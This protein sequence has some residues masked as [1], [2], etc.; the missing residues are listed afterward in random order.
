MVVKFLTSCQYDIAA[1]LLPREDKIQILENA[2]TKKQ[3]LEIVY[4]KAKD[5]K[6]RRLIKPLVVGDMEHK[7]HPFIGLEALCMTRREKRVFNVDKILE[8]VESS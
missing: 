7:G 5:E 8:I 1:R 3:T 6:T 4:L 2:I